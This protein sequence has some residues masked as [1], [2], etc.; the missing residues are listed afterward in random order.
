MP[1]ARLKTH[2]ILLLEVS[3]NISLVMLWHD[4]VPH[5]KI[6]CD[7]SRLVTNC[8]QKSSSSGC[9]LK[10]QFALKTVTKYFCDPI[11]DDR[12]TS[13]LVGEKVQLGKV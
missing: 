2:G 1:K 3:E 6:S 11:S 13:R 5:A 4:I 7:K 10:A 9:C 12:K 8:Y